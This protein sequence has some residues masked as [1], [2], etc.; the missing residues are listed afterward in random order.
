MTDR[1]GDAMMRMYALRASHDADVR[2]GRVPLTGSRIWL[3]REDGHQLA[4]ELG[5]SSI[6]GKRYMTLPISEAGH[7]SQSRVV[8]SDG[9]SLTI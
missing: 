6:W 4:A 2:P 5:V 1:L 8:L 7:L 9:R 3:T